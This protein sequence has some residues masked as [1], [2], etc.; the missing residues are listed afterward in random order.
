MHRVVW[1]PRD[2]KATPQT[3]PPMP[4]TPPADAGT[5]A[6]STRV[7]TNTASSGEARVAAANDPSLAYNAVGARTRR[8]TRRAAD[9][10]WRLVHPP[11]PPQGEIPRTIE[12]GA[13]QRLDAAG[14]LR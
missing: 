9:W 12:T 10:S 3:S 14:R 1:L 13:H 2:W 4:S 7:M 8:P 5:I 11:Q 6:A